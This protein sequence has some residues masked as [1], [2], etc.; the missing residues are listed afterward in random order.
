MFYVQSAKFSNFDS[1]SCL[2]KDGTAWDHFKY[3][4]TRTLR[5]HN[6]ETRGKAAAIYSIVQ[7]TSEISE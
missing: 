2:I 5:F 7:A 1:V 6:V 4:Y 3:E